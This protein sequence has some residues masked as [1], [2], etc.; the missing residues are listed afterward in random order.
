[1]RGVTT[2][3][4]GAAAVA[5]LL[6]AC[7]TGDDATTDSGPTSAPTS[8]PTDEPTTSGESFPED[9]SLQFAESSGEWDLV[10]ADGYYSGPQQFEPAGGGD[11]DDVYVA[12]TFEGYTQVIAGIDDARAPFRAFALTGPPRL[13]VDVSDTAD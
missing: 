2:A 4:L 9:T 1:M 6:T 5:L 7:G 8:A 10:P 3:L 11:V 12:G 13:V